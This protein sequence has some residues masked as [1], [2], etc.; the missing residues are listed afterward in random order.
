MKPTRDKSPQLKQVDAAV[1]STVDA[2]SPACVAQK[3]TPAEP[4]AERCNWWQTV[5]TEGR[6][7][8][9]LIAV[10]GALAIT[11]SLADDWLGKT[12]S[13]EEKRIEKMGTSPGDAGYLQLRLARARLFADQYA[14]MNALQDLA[15]Y[16]WYHNDRAGAIKIYE[17]LTPRFHSSDPDLAGINFWSMKD[18]LLEYYIDTNNVAGRLKLFE[19]DQNNDMHLP[20]ADSVDTMAEAADLYAVAGD[21]AN[22]ARWKRAAEIGKTIPVMTLDDNYKVAPYL[23]PEL[24][25]AID[26]SDG[27][28]PEIWLS[29]G[30]NRLESDPSHSGACFLKALNDKSAS[31]TQVARAKIWLFI[32]CVRSE[33]K[34]QAARVLPDAMAAES[35]L[36]K[37]QLNAHHGEGV[38]VEEASFWTVYLQYLTDIKDTKAAAATAEHEQE[39]M[40][41]AAGPRLAKIQI[42]LDSDTER[43]R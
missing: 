4:A 25:P 37:T 27:Y 30:I 34:T 18:R 21:K 39:V 24:Y 6:K 12:S 15:N 33:D 11:L 28:A 17:D 36:T 3:Q 5:K 29:L 2:L 9:P 1:D 26:S 42:D 7:Q 43:N 41:R 19:L 8:F 13:L 22:A 31:P 32:S 40:K 23:D 10:A 20:C 35:W 16:K 38:S 14:E